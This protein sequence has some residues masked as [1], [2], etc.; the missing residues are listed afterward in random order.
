[1]RKLASIGLAVIV[2]AGIMVATPASAATISN[3]VA[4]AKSGASSVV[5]GRKYKCGKNPLTTSSKLVW[6]SNDCL[7]SAASYLKAKGTSAVISATYA[8][9]I[10][11]IDAQIVN[12][13]TVR[14]TIQI[15]LD[16]ATLRLTA[17]KEKLALAKTDASKKLLTSAVGSW[18]SAVRAY[19]SE[20]NQIAAS[21]RKLDAAKL[22]AVN[23]P[24]ELASSIASS[25]STAQLICTTGL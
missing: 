3:G 1:M 18:N 17:A 22:V 14:D 5:S 19:T 11:T 13:N 21:V 12:A 16:A 25:K 7:V 9:Q 8:A 20:I 4:C 6:L 2:G 10:P 24:A 15:K 23:K